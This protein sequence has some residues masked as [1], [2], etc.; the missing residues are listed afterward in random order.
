MDTR[1]PMVSMEEIEDIISCDIRGY[2]CGTRQNVFASQ[3]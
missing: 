2:E 1:I 3:Y